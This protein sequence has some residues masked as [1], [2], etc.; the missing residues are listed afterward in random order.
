MRA[1]WAAGTKAFEGERV[2]LPETTSY[3]RPVSSI[4]VIVGGGGERRTLRIAALLADGV[5]LSSTTSTLDHKIAVLR[6]HCVAVGRN[7]DD[8]EITV[9]D[10]PV[11]GTDRDDVA[12]RVERLRGRTAA[13]AYADRHHAGT[14]A[15]QIDRY[16]EL[17]R[18]GVRT[19][20]VAPQG[21]T[22]A[23]E[24]EPFGAITAAFR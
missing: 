15:Q 9:L 11:V 5:N 12:A 17:V 14:P 16:R 4:P 19:V 18:R 22:G 13:R 1:L 3:P 10:L 20:F 8:V 24:I 23:R 2:A 21:L 6:E 7:P